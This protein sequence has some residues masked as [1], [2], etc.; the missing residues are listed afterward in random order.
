MQCMSCE[1]EINPK[2]KHAVTNNSCPFCGNNIL[3]E[4]LKELFS[5]LENTINELKEKYLSQLDDW[6]L[7]NYNYINTNS[8]K[9]I[10]YVPKHKLINNSKLISSSVKES[11]DDESDKEEI[12]DD[13]DEG[14]ITGVQ[15]SHVTEQFFK[16]AG[17][18]RAVER[19][20]E[21]KKMAEQI[22]AQN[23]SMKKKI[24]SYEED[25]LD[26]INSSLE[27]SYDDGEEEIHPAAFA[28]SQSRLSKSSADY[29][30]K[31]M[32]KLQELHNKNK[33]ARSVITNG[34]GKSSF[35]RT[36]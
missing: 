22:K 23:P 4:E 20:Q 32:M 6:M 13:M 29:S 36:G 1:S 25:D 3:P 17:V 8:D 2:W 27:S 18:S 5:L 10:N 19:S 24:S 31:D 15:D 11:L 30:A 26:E 28:L 33:Q 7:S 34:S 14:Q 35:T 21:L 16:A 12:T 9:L